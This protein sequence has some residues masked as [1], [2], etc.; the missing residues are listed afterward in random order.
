MVDF[1]ELYLGQVEIE[2]LLGLQA[3]LEISGVGT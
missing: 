2:V 1:Y 3:F